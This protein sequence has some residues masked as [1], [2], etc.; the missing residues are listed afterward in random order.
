MATI[1]KDAPA[2]NPAVSEQGAGQLLRRFPAGFVWGVATSAYQI[3]GAAHEDGRADSIWDVFCRR[4]GSIRD[5]SSGTVACD[6]YHRF[7]GDLDLIAGL[8]I[9]AYRFSVSWPRVQPLGRGA[10]NE[11]G[12]AFYAR[13]IEGLRRR[14]IAAHAT[15]NHWDLPQALQERGGWENRDTVHAFVGYAVEFARRF[16]AELASIA[17]HNEPWVV[18]ILGHEQ[19]IFAPGLKNRR[20]AIQ[21]AHHL[22]VSHGL[23]LRAIRATGCVVPLGIVLNQ[24]PIH[25]A[26]ESATDIAKARLEDGLIIRWYMDPLLRGEYPADVIEY[27]GNDAPSVETGDM[28]LIRQPLDFLGINYYTRS[29][30]QTGERKYDRGSTMRVTDMGWEVFPDGLTELL[31]RLD[32][33]YRLPAVYIME[34]GAAY[35]DEV[36]DGRVADTD[37]I[38]FL[39]THIAALADAV[40]TGVGVRGYFVWSLLDNFEWA[41]GYSKRFGIVHVDYDTQQRIAKDSAVWYR[42]FLRGE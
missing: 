37:R 39:R 42:D 24:S 40:E 3:E 16:G 12:F 18:A 32:A 14:G 13:L 25:A 11:A 7:D 28:D 10:W 2:A 36:I 41:D 6:H 19:G 27:L 38:E 21:V 15:L 23:A 26:T 34:N 1:I 20:T 8:G 9:K 30:A 4:A 33:D 29:I 5:G 17:T 31:V 35:K 22:L